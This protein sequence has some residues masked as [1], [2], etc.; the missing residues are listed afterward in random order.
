MV[1]NDA[2]NYVDLYF[3]KIVCR[4]EH[5]CNDTSCTLHA[6]SLFER[7]Y[8][9]YGYVSGVGVGVFLWVGTCF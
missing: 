3:I 4:A 6:C 5:N 9:I 8:A 7:G 2:Y 1:T